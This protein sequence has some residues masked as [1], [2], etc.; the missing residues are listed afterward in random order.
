MLDRE[1]IDSMREKVDDFFEDKCDL[2]LCLDICWYIYDDLHQNREGVLDFYEKSMALIGD[3]VT[4]VVSDIEGRFKKARKGTLD[5]LPYWVAESEQHDIAEMLILHCDPVKESHSDH[6]FWMEL[7]EEANGFIR[8]MLPLEYLL[9]GADKLVSLCQSLGDKLVF[10]NGHAGYGVNMY[11]GYPASFENSK[12]YALSRRFHGIDF[13]DPFS[14]DRFTENHIKCVNWLTFVG[15]PLLQRLGGRQ[16]LKQ[17][18]EEGIIIHDL[19]HGVIV[20]AGP[21]PGFG[22]VNHNDMLPYY[23]AAGRLLKE[24]RASSDEYQRWDGVGGGSNTDAWLSR[25]DQ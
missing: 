6:A 3:K 18:A 16:T 9:D 14:V 20:Q 11:P 22:D 4:W 23:H 15:D 24:L 25:F 2:R 13:G 1:Q 17:R 8:L 10:R 21:E 12:I 5:I 7:V 19:P